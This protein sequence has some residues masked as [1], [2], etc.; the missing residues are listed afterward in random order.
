VRS[1]LKTVTPRTI[2]V[3]FDMLK[4]LILFW[5]LL[6]RRTPAMWY[7]PAAVQVS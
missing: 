6:S 5:V 3:D 4:H 1:E 2:C 7:T